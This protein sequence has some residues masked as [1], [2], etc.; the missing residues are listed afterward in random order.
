MSAMCCLNVIDVSYVTP[1]ILGVWVCVRGVLLM[2]RLGVWRC[3]DVQFVRSVL[4]DLAGARLSL[5]VLHQS[6][7]VSRYGWR[8]CAAVSALGCVLVIVMSSA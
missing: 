4:V 5:F 6:W 2:V 7:R 3:S 1:R 8:C